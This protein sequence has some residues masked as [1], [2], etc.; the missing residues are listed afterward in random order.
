MWNIRSLSFNWIRGEIYF[1][2]V[3]LYCFRRTYIGNLCLFAVQL[4]AWDDIAKFSLIG[5]K[6]R[7]G[8]LLEIVFHLRFWGLDFSWYGAFCGRLTAQLDFCG[9]NLHRV[10][11][12]NRLYQKLS[13]E[14]CLI[15]I[16]IYQIR[17]KTYFIVFIIMLIYVDSWNFYKPRVNIFC[18]VSSFYLI[19][20]YL[21]AMKVSVS[22]EIKNECRKWYLDEYSD[23][24]QFSLNFY[25]SSKN[26][27][28]K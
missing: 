24:D 26:K 22:L 16:A 1:Q 20:R 5:R 19:F 13:F 21:K 14:I 4:K 8:L 23:D 17:Q 18:F 28:I 25:L 12:L 9:A 27:V 3:W 2:G 11:I 6:D 15:D 7:N 10:W